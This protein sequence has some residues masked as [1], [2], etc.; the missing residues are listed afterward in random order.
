MK[1]RAPFV[2]PTPTNQTPEEKKKNAASSILPTKYHG[3]CIA[4]KSALHNSGFRQILE[5]IC[6][7][8][9]RQNLLVVNPEL[10]VDPSML[11]TIEFYLIKLFF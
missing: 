10:R 2:V 4:L 5:N 9:K 7:F 8:E 11:G 6:E 1:K 3:M